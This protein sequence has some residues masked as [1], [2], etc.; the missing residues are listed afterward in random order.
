VFK[1]RRWTGAKY[2]L[3]LIIFRFG[4]KGRRTF[5]GPW[6]LAEAPVILS[7]PRG[8]G[9]AH[10]E[11]RREAS[12]RRVKT[13]RVKSHRSRSNFTWRQMLS[14]DIPVSSPEE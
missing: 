4:K 14:Q 13:A 12:W 7:G 1:T 5:M 6:G 3:K 9:I 8:D 11:I 10:Y 2:Q